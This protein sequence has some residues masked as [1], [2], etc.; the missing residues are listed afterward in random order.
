MA[1]GRAYARLAAL[2]GWNTLQN[3]WRDAGLHAPAVLRGQA[4]GYGALVSLT[5]QRANRS[6]DLGRHGTQCRGTPPMWGGTPNPEIEMNSA[7]NA[8]PARREKLFVLRWLPPLSAQIGAVVFVCQ[9]GRTHHVVAFSA[10]SL[11]LVTRLA[12]GDH[13]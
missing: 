12:D 13:A 10:I 5:A 8:S 6:V 9:R 4:C 7:S 3:L 11:G 1:T 2:C